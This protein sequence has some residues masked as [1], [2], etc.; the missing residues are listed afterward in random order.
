MSSD[1]RKYD[2][3]IVGSGLGGLLC[4]YI[5][6]REGL[7]VCIVEKSDVI[8]GCL[9]TFSRGGSIFDTGIHYV[10]SLDEGQA[11]HRYFQYFGLNGRINVKRLDNDCFDKICFLTDNSQ[12]EY[13]SGPDNF[14]EKLGRHFPSERAALKKYVQKLE[15]IYNSFGMLNLENTTGKFFEKSEAM[16]NAHDYIASLT[17][18]TR[19]RN[20]LAGINLLYAGVAKK[21]PLY[22]HALIN[23]SYMQS[24]YR[25][26]DG[27]HQV[28]D[29]LA[30]QITGFGGSIIR[31]FN[32]VK[33]GF[34]GNTLVNVES[35]EG[36]IVWGKNFVSNIHPF[37][38][39][40]I[41]GQEHV[42]KIYWERISTL[43]NTTSAFITYL[44]L[45]KGIIPYNNYNYYIYNYNNVWNLEKNSKE[46]WPANIFCF[47]PAYSSGFES[48]ESLILMT[49]MDFEQVRKWEATSIGKRGR[50]YLDF[51]SAC[52]QKM[53]EL[54]ETKFPGIRDAIVSITTSSPL[55]FR[56]YTGSKDGSIY[57]V[58]RDC[59][60]PLKSFVHYK[61]K[62]P[63]LLLTGQNTIMHG[64]LGVTI[65]SVVAASELL[66]MD[67][68]LNRIRKA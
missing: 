59:T 3:V 24:A 54:A 1:T 57:G 53:I 64:M 45:K 47:T 28:A 34:L 20:V 55:T 48:A 58:L 26:I 29:I 61:T 7:S 33:F 6:S 52:A 63:N 68:L 32:A 65:G 21:S 17:S 13:A 12:Y 10:G 5:L 11:L 60:E 16:G 35:S 46:T 49:Y 4:G 41:L 31:N 51:K 8:G 50:A 62:I 25:F 9:Q 39:I 40:N 37:N 56:D 42:R 67:Y 23:Y 22:V 2:V 30:E 66:G 27:S 19:L 14:I 18:D 36:D 15:A 44:K 38:T 43:E